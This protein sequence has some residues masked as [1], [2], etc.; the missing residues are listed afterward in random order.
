MSQQIRKC[1]PTWFC[2]L[3]TH[4]FSLLWVWGIKTPQGRK[5]C[6]ITALTPSDPKLLLWWKNDGYFGILQLNPNNFDVK[7]LSY[8]LQLFELFQFLHKYNFILNSFY[9][10][11]MCLNTKISINNSIFQLMKKK[12]YGNI[13]IS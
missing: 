6:C 8:T 10:Y 9:S 7:I 13:P 5:V 11:F 3:K 2:S 1:C 12:R 4:M